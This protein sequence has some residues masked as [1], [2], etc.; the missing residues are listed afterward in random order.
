MSKTIIST[1]MSLVLSIASTIT[2]AADDGEALYNTNSCVNCH[3]S[4][5]VKTIMPTY[6]KLAGQNK[7]YLL[8]VMKNIKNGDRTDGMSSV[9]QP[10]LQGLSE[11]E[12][13]AIAEWLSQLE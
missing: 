4:K 2:Y 5:G 13:E 12:I 1:I 9:M 8:L 11:T 7:D 10:I 6:P 3:G